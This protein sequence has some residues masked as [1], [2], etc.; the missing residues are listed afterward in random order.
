MGI[1]L[2]I[3]KTRKRTI[4]RTERAQ[5]SSHRMP[6]VMYDISPRMWVFILVLSLFLVGLLTVWG[7]W[8]ALV[9]CYLKSENLFT[10]KDVRRNVTIT[11]GKTLTPDLL[12][13]VLQL[14]EGV[15]LFSIPIDKR[16]RDLMEWAPNIRELSI[17]RRLPDKLTISVVEREPIARLGQNGCVTDEEG[18]VFVRYAGTGRLPLIQGADSL[19]QIKPGD[20]LHG[21]ALSAVRLVENASRPECKSR[22]LVIDVKQEEF[23]QLT[24]SDHR[25]ANF[26]WPGMEDDEKNTFYSMQKHFDQ[27]GTIMESEAGRM[28]RIFDARVPGRITARLPVLE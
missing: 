6:D 20:Q 26:A 14:K 17:V 28:C 10:L 2:N 21:I 4:Q 25:M 23:F 3:F 11:T 1:Q 22:I 5:R 16:R 27:L 13:E 12:L 18:I 24:F 19:S 15:N 7:L 8:Y 9:N